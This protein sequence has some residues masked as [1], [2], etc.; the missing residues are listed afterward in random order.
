MRRLS[1]ERHLLP[2]LITRVPSSGPTWSEK[3]THCPSH[4]ITAQSVTPKSTRTT[5]PTA[6]CGSIH[7]NPSTL[8]TEGENHKWVRP[9]RPL[10]AA[11]L[12]STFVTSAQCYTL[13]TPIPS[14]FKTALHSK[15][16]DNKT[17]KQTNICDKIHTE[18]HP[19]T[20]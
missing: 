1:R 18:N 11:R 3:I 5:L 6:R 14:L 15:Q 4:Q 7:L 12:S 17:P 2:S 9:A 19:R 8:G 13:A 16:R 20:Q 10:Q